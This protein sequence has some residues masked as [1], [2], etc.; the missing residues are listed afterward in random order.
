MKE[1]RLRQAVALVGAQAQKM[2]ASVERRSRL[3]DP[4]VSTAR[5]SADITRQYC[6]QFSA[7][8]EVFDRIR[9]TKP[10]KKRDIESF[11]AVRELTRTATLLASSA[12][13]VI[14][15]SRLDIPALDVSPEF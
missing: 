5:V 14:V 7:T 6:H 12:L 11:T 10:S 1:Q 8:L 2:A 4:P 9:K 15:E 3:E 13:G